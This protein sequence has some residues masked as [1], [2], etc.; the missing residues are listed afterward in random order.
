MNHAA[1]DEAAQRVL[2]H[3]IGGDEA[4]NPA[5]DWGAWLARRGYVVLTGWS[6]IRHYRG[7]DGSPDCFVSVHV[8]SIDDRSFPLPRDVLSPCVKQRP[9]N[10]S[11]SRPFVEFDCFVGSIIIL[12]SVQ[13]AANDGLI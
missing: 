13:Q 9:L 5:Y 10:I 6:F 8:L 2:L 11:G 1:P 4:G 7:V 3:D 12:K